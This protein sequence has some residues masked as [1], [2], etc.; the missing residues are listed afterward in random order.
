M[1]P[2]EPLF[3]EA[4]LLSFNQSKHF[5]PVGHSPSFFEGH[6][7]PH[8]LSASAQFLPQRVRTDTDDDPS[9]V[10]LRVDVL[11]SAKQS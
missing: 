2:E 9:V 3:E 5:S 4:H 8:F 10:M 1:L 11:V 7:V 6:K